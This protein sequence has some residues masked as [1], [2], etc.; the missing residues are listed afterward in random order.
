MTYAFAADITRRVRVA[1]VRARI[2]SHMAARHGLPPD[3]PITDLASHDPRAAIPGGPIGDG[4]RFANATAVEVIERR[5]RPFPGRSS[6]AS[7]RS[8]VGGPPFASPRPG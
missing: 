7:V 2:E 8:T 6:V 3:P 5:G 1:R 4:S